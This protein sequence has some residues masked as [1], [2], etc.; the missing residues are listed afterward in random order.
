V[1]TGQAGFCLDSRE[2]HSP[3][4]KLHPSTNQSPDSFQESK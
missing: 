4:E 1:E 2:E 3:W